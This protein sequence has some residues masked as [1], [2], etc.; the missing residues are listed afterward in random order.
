MF[1]FACQWLHLTAT[2]IV[3]PSLQIKAALEQQNGASPSDEEVF[4]ELLSKAVVDKDAIRGAM[5]AAKKAA[6]EK[7]AAEAAAAAAAEQADATGSDA[8]AA[9]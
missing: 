3:C 5:A 1:C 2:C 9:E 4:T 8:P 6:D 7:T